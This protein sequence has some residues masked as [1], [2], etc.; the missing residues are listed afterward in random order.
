MKHPRILP[1]LIIPTLVTSA[2]AAFQSFEGDGFD[3]WKTTGTAFGL[4]P[5]HGKLDEMEKAFSSF[6]D[7]S[8][9]TSA[10]GGYEATGSLESPEFTIKANYI[11]FLIAGGKHPGTAAVQLLVD[12]KVEFESTGE[13]TLRFSPSQWD[14]SKLQGKR[15]TIRVVDEEK[16]DWGMIAV[17]E[18]TF[19]DRSNPKFPPSTKN[20]Q[21]FFEGLDSTDVLPGATIPEGSTLKIEATY[22]NLN[23]TSPTASDLR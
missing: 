5:V 19:S 1:F 16:G 12:G 8:F 23:V 11:S 3:A 14:V 13:N 4:S 7:N 6:S 9:A 10:H 18:I 2:N 22:E 21:L 17:D 20:G 15:A